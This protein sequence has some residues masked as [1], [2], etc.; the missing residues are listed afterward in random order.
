MMRLLHNKSCSGC[1]RQ[2]HCGRKAL[3]NTE[4]ANICSA[5]DFAYGQAVNGTVAMCKLATRGITWGS[6]P[7]KLENKQ[8]RTYLVEW[9]P[10]QPN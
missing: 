10:P 6:L 1:Y 2:L 8:V 9:R 7:V 3:S 5:Q 4:Q